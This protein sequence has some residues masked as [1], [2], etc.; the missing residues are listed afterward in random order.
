MTA[1]YVFFCRYQS[2]AT[3]AAASVRWRWELPLPLFRS[4]C[5]TKTECEWC[6]IFTG[7]TVATNMDTITLLKQLRVTKR[8]EEAAKVVGEEVQTAEAS[9]SVKPNPTSSILIVNPLR[10]LSSLSLGI[11][12]PWGS[13]QSCKLVL[14]LW[15]CIYLSCLKLGD[16]TCAWVENNG[17]KCDHFVTFTTILPKGGPGFCCNGACPDFLVGL[18]LGSVATANDRH[19]WKFEIVWEIKIGKLVKY[20][21]SWRTPK[22][23][24][25]YF[26]P[27]TKSAWSSLIL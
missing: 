15:L 14:Q 4:S 5:T 18:L 22:T 1:L 17:I 9:T 3:S 8:R 27:V 16:F 6:K 21:G 23:E 11:Q 25:S 10:D 2:P 19:F 24:G 20:S 12:N 26:G 13:L 7:C